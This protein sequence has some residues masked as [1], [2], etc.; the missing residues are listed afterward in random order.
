MKPNTLVMGYYDD[1]IPESQLDHLYR[2]V[3]K[4]PRV[5]RSLIRDQGLE[6]YREVDEQL[7]H[8]RRR[9][10]VYCQQ[11][12]PP[13]TSHIPTCVMFIASVCCSECLLLSLG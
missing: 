5:V 8:L 10:S 4:W 7:P 3:E 1:S 9:V 2:K 6:K 13:P 11:N 12:L